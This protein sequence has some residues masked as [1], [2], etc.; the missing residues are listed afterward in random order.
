MAEGATL[1]LVGDGAT[2]AI[3]RRD[4]LDLSAETFGGMADVTIRLTPAATERLE[5]FTAALVGQE[6]GVKSCGAELLRVRIVEAIAGGS[7]TIGSLGLDEALALRLALQGGA[8]C[9]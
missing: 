3:P 2:L 9:P 7:L 5:V 8:G 6:I 4:V 1:A